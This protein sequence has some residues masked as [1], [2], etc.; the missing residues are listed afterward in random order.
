M[1]KSNIICIL[2][3]TAV[4]FVV[5]LFWGCG[6]ITTEEE[7]TVQ[8][9]QATESENQTNSSCVLY[10]DVPLDIAL[11]NHIFNLAAEY[12]INPKYII[13]IIAE[14]SAFNA[15]TTGDNGA[16]IG[17]MQIQPKWHGERIKRL[18]CFNLYD[19]FQNITVGVDY[20]SELLNKYDGD[21]VK[22]IV[23]YQ[24]GSFKG[25]VTPYAADV[26]LTAASLGVLS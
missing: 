25:E 9:V 2:A 12:C 10:Y 22:A 26:L 20:L 16:S 3:I 13:A 24:Q 21:I 23:A 1:K 4:V 14:E 6:D 11:Q 8:N 19:P 5:L 18:S 15:Q 7:T 17:L